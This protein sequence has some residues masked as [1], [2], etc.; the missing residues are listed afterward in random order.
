LSEDV[1]WKR[2]GWDRGDLLGKTKVSELRGNHLKQKRGEWR[3]PR[4]IKNT[5]PRRRSGA[6]SYI[7]GEKS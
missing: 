2:F 7:E 3:G 6:K 5:G 1:C 4:V